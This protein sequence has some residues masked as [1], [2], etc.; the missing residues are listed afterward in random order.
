MID[1]REHINQRVNRARLALELRRSSRPLIVVAIGAVAALAGAFWVAKNVSQTIYTPA[2]T[3]RFVVSDANGVQGGQRDDLR[4]KGVQAGKVESVKLV[5]GQAIVTAQLY[6]RFGPIYRNATVALRPNSALEDMYLD[7]LDRGS[8]D[9]GELTPD[10]PLAVRHTD[11]AV[12]VEDVLQAFSP[13][14]RAHMAVMLRNLGGGLADRGYQLQ[15]AFVATAPLVRAADRMAAQLARRGDLTRRLVHNTGVL[16]GE[17]ARRDESLRR[18]VADGATTLSAVDPRRGD[19]EAT[20][21]ELPTFLQHVDS[22]FAAVRGVLPS[23][24]AA[25]RSLTPAARRLPSGLAALR[26]LSVA[27]RPAVSALR[28]PV[29]KLVPLATQLRPF[30]GELQQAISLL[31]PQMRALDHVTR[32]TAGCVIGIEA[33]FQWTPALGKEAD[34]RG[35]PG[36]RGDMALGLDSSGR[37]DPRVKPLPSCAPGHPIGGVAGPG[38]DLKP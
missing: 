32:A 29:R 19:L 18:L 36:G 21:A 1:P 34:A 5:H 11:V 30:A 3:L 4:F 10:T 31:R 27:G 24:N 28:P 14:V 23:V 37:P 26:Q 20:L 35:T 33:F 22:S 7:I 16:T 13:D 25:V 15:K 38:G 17:L 12:Q 8:K 9:T 6:R 2:R